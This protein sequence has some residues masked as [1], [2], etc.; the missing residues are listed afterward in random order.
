MTDDPFQIPKQF[1]SYASFI[2]YDDLF[3]SNYFNYV[4]ELSE[5]H[6]SIL[7]ILESKRVSLDDPQF[8]RFTELLHLKLKDVL[9]SD[10]DELKTFNDWS[11]FH[12][13]FLKSSSLKL[14]DVL[15]IEEGSQ[16]YSH[17]SVVIDDNII[18]YDIGE[19]PELQFDFV[20]IATN[21]SIKEIIE[22]CHKLI[23][24]KSNIK[25]LKLSDKYECK[26]IALYHFYSYQTIN[27]EN[28]DKTAVAYGYKHG[29]KLY[30]NYN[31][32]IKESNRVSTGSKS[33]NTWKVKYFEQAK[34]LLQQNNYQDQLTRIN[35]DFENFK[36]NIEDN[37]QL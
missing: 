13:Y 28:R 23:K 34:E 6:K 18:A 21:V 26:S 37:L 10:F 3:R 14:N 36:K 16:L 24:A 20:K 25:K 27:M 2:K 4:K 15:N 9:Y 19:I 17:L 7:N 12:H 29:S 33:H 11:K 30:E 32:Y 8:L 5:K 22:Y 1:N 31:F 35:K